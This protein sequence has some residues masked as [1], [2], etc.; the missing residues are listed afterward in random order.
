MSIQIGQSGYGLLSPWWCNQ[1]AT[2]LLSSLAAQGTD[3]SGWNFLSDQVDSD[4][5]FNLDKIGEKVITDLAGV[6]AG[7]L[8]DKEEL[9]EDYVVAIIDQADGSY[10]ARTYRRSEL[11]ESIENPVSKAMLKKTLETN[12]LLHL[13]DDEGLPEP[14]ADDADLVN[15]AAKIQ[16]FLDQN[17]KTI[18]ML[19]RS[20]N[21]PW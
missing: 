13:S 20:G 16:G 14:A 1:Q 15:F 5:S 7:Y 10:E 6:A 11:L 2:N 18:A 17:Q 3:N 12:P 4:V 8:K 21:M 9:S 19:D